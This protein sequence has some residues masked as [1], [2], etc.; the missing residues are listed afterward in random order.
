MKGAALLCMCQQYKLCDSMSK[1]RQLCR[2]NFGHNRYVWESGIMPACW[3]DYKALLMRKSSICF[4]R[5]RYS[6][7][8]VRNSN[9]TVIDCHILYTGRKVEFPIVILA[10]EMYRSYRLHISIRFIVPTNFSCT[11]PLIQ[12]ILSRPDLL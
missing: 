10:Q 4:K 1:V 11:F 5:S 7:R 12:D 2:H 9:R 3:G 6:Y 8:A